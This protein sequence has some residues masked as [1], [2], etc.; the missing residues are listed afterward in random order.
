MES[1][2]NY[3]KDCEKTVPIAEGEDDICPDCG[4]SLVRVSSLR[5]VQRSAVEYIEW[6]KGVK[7][8]GEWGPSP[9]GAAA[10]LGC[11]R[12][13]I[14][15]LVNMGVLVRNESPANDGNVRTV[16]ISEASIKQ[17]IENKK[18]TGNWTGGSKK[19]S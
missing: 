6:A 7:E 9:G 19:K 4:A 3:C 2:K 16:M 14:D 1:I 5:G 10:Q 15:H 18:R 17:A 8:R 11:T 12:S 13:M